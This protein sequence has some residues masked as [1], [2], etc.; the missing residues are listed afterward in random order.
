MSDDSFR[1]VAGDAVFGFSQ[2]ADQGG[3]ELSPPT[4][5][6]EL[7]SWLADYID[8]YPHHTTSVLS[9]MQYIGVGKRV[10]D[11]YIAGTYFRPRCEGGQGVNPAESKIEH[12][13]RLYRQRVEGSERHGY[14]N[15]FIET[16]VWL[17]LKQA[18]LAAM[19]EH[20]IVVVYG[21]PGVGKSR[22]LI[23]F[24]LREMTVAPVSIMCSRNVTARYL[25]SKLAESLRLHDGHSSAYLEEI[26]AEKLKRSPRPLFIDQANYLCERALGSICFI[27]EVARVPIVLI[28]TKDLYNLFNSTKL[29]EDIKAQLASLVALHYVLPELALSEAKV[30]IERALK[31]DA[32]DETIAQIYSVTGGI[33]RHVDMI[34]PRIL[35]L[36]VKNETKLLTGEVKMSDV[37]RTA[38]S[39]L[40]TG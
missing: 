38:A 32:S 3:E 29:R 22:C 35:E 7:R 18:C 19:S 8:K 11:A 34:L 13:I 2:A 21:R 14:T 9:H 15:P 4:W 26:V 16:R 10:L 33:H 39:R 17:Q 25:L 31:Q 20:V 27:W 37:I 5:D 36:K 1:K 30:I 28:G 6:E 40:M 12:S 23:E 24:C